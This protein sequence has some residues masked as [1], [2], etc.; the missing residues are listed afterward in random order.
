MP[1]SPQDD[2]LPSYVKAERLIHQQL[3]SMKVGERLL[4]EREL[5]SE[6]GISRVTLRRAMEKFH[7]E[8]F[9]EGRRGGGTWLIRKVSTPPQNSSS[10]P[11]SLRFIGLALPAVENSLI[12]RISRGALRCAHDHD[13][14]LILIYDQEEIQSKIAEIQKMSKEGIGGFAIYPSAAHPEH[15]KMLLQSIEKTK[16]EL[17]MIDRYIPD[18]NAV[19]VLSDNFS[20]MYAA[21]EHMI[22][23]GHR[24]LGLLGFGP[25]GG[26]SD[27]DRRKGFL[28]A[29]NDY[30]LPSSPVLEADLGVMDH[31]IYAQQKVDEWIQQNEGR[32]PF[33]GLVC[34]QDNMAYGAYMALKKAGIQVPQQ[35][36]LVGYDNLDRE[37][38]H[39]S[40]LE[41]TSIDQPSEQIGYEAIRLLIEKM[42][43]KEPSSRARHILLKPSLIVRNS[44]K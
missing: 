37:I 6:I 15:D 21:T 8:G 2:Y 29:L 11:T 38:F 31:E 16:S 41:L 10:S 3:A 12:S 26:I 43:G 17:V 20:G 25:E 40:G 22:L 18:V 30:K 13:Y 4:S 44:C 5:C 35:V 32:I 27:R 42:E 23:T 24:R 34:M 39:A 36:A 9:L 1:S 14:R 19:C 7:R 33:D 28:A